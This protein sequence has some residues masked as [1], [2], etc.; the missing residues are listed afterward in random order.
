M[1]IIWD[2]CIHIAIAGKQISDEAVIAASGNHDVFLSVISLGELTFGVNSCADPAEQ[3]VRMR[4]LRSLEK[5]PILDITSLTASA[6][7]IVATALKSS[8]RSPRTRYND[9]WIAAQALENDYS[10]LTLNPTDFA[11]IPAITVVTPS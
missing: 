8:G 5:R 11:S 4:Y 7:G 3:I 10:I 2:T 9:M 6:F 1:G